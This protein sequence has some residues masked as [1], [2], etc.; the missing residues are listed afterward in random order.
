MK[1]ESPVVVTREPGGTSL[2]VGLRQLL[3]E[4]SP[5][6]DRAEL[7]LYA[8]DRAQHIEEFLKPQLAQWCSYFM[9]SLYGFDAG[10]SRL[11]TGT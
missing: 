3:L 1:P 6:Q 2:G 5:I 8:A 4:G 11:W 10:L 9:R 7:L